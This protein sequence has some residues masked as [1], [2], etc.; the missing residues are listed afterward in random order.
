MSRCHYG[1]ACAD[2]V[3]KAG[4]RC[5]FPAIG[6]I[7]HHTTLKAPRCPRLV[8]LCVAV[9]CCPWRVISD[10]GVMMPAQLR[11]RCKPQSAPQKTM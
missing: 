7:P 10:I 8:N 2:S 11:G 6:S 3:F 4:D 5:A 9:Q 1:Q